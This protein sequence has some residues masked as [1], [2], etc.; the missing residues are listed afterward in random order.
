MKSGA[1]AVFNQ[2]RGRESRQ[3]VVTSDSGIKGQLPL[4]S[5]GEGLLWWLPR[6]FFLLFRQQTR[7]KSKQQ[8][9][10]RKG[11]FE[12]GNFQQKRG[13][14]GPVLAGDSHRFS[15]L[16]DRRSETKGGVGISSSCLIGEE[17]LT[18]RGTVFDPRILKIRKARQRENRAGI[19]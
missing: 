5:S 13:R 3:K 11:L 17:K 2:S 4:T 10:P 9:Q 16:F 15:S 12:C 19:E 18:H 1:S 6:R 14:G 8:Q 7:R